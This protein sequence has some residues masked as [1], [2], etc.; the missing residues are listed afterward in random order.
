MLT[1]IPLE[2]LIQTIEHCYKCP[3]SQSR[4]KPIIGNGNIQSKVM[5]VGEGPGKTENETG[6]AF[7]GPA[8]LLLDKMLKYAGLDRNTV[9]LTNVV[10][11]FPPAGRTPRPTETKACINYLRD[12]YLLQKPQLIIC[13]GAIACKSLIDDK[14]SILRQHGQPVTKKGVIF[15]PTFHP[16]A[17]LRDETKKPEAVKDW[18]AIKKLVEERQ[19]NK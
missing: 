11:C 7:T 13:L 8:G 17:I 15:F 2:N 12:Q 19:F 10:K 16:A 14:F 1:L 3:L 18:T 4:N 9:Y 5:V 6:V